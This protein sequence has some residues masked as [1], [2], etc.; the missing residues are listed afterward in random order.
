MGSNSGSGLF[1]KLKSKITIKQDTI[2][3]F[4]GVNMVL[5]IDSNGILNLT[6]DDKTIKVKFLNGPYKNNSFVYNANSKP[7]VRIGRSRS[8]EIPLRD[9]S[10]SRIQCV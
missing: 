5:S 8:V 4:C 2:V 10:V 9:C 1:V 6:L 3:A 7:I